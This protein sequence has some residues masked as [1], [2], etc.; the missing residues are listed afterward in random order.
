MFRKH[1][2]FLSRKVIAL[3]IA[4]CSESLSSYTCVRLSFTG[5]L[6]VYFSQQLSFMNLQFTKSA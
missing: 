1:I 5:R 4:N 6:D 3:K 2:Y